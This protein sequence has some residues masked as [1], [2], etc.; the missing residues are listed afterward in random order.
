M[1]KALDSINN[2]V[3]DGSYDRGCMSLEGNILSLDMN[4][5]INSYGPMVSSIS[6]RMIRNEED[7]KDAAQEAWVEILK[8]VSGYRGDAGISTWI[9]TVAYH[10]V[11]N[12]SK[13]D[14]LY[15]TRFLKDYFHKEQLDIPYNVD[16]DKDIWIKEMCDKCLTG[17]LHC[18]D[19]ES[20]MAYLFRDVA[21]LPYE[22]IGEILEKDPSSLRKVVSRSRA[23]LNNFLNSE[24]MLYNPKGTCKCRMKNLVTDIKLADEYSKIRVLAGRVNLYLESQKVL[25]QKNYWEKYLI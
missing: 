14:K 9:Y 13:K 19:T 10:S 22:N 15:S 16:Y 23:K 1:Q 7:A 21:G 3:S 8:G 25:P 11:I 2:I 24:C 12:Y 4:T 5:I 20:R 17:I 6:R 18:L